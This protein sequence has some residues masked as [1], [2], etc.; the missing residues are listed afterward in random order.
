MGYKLKFSMTQSKHTIKRSINMTTL[1]IFLIKD[2]GNS[3][4]RYNMDKLKDI[5]LREISQ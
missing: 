4:I 2:E 1:K 5:M 3:S